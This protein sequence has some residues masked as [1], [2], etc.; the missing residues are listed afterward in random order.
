M[1]EADRENDPGRVTSLDEAGENADV[2]CTRC[3]GGRH[4][5]QASEGPLKSGPGDLGTAKAKVSAARPRCWSGS[6][7]NHGRFVLVYWWLGVWCLWSWGLEG[8]FR[9][10]V[11]IY[12]GQA[13]IPL[14]R[15]RR[16]FDSGCGPRKEILE[17]SRWE[18]KK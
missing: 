1:A 7:D 11:H 13:E 9:R 2:A 5:E 8:E 17:L 15:V 14:V 6:G 4:Y 16:L 10:R 18:P 3:A 12:R